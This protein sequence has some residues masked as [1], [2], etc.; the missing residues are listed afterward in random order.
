MKLL[1]HRLDAARFQ[2]SLNEGRELLLVG[3]R[4]V[5]LKLS[6]VF[7]DMPAIDELLVQFRIIL[8]LA[9]FRFAGSRESLLRMG[10]VQTTIN[11]ALNINMFEMI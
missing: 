1:V 10:N 8:G 3:F 2:T 7:G 6:H 4:V 11:S 5:F 9:T